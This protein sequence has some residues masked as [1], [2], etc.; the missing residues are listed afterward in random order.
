MT[1]NDGQDGRCGRLDRAIQVDDHA[2]GGGEGGCQLDTSCFAE[3]VCLGCKEKF[4]SPGAICDPLIRLAF[5]GITLGNA[6]S[7]GN[8]QVSSEFL[9]AGGTCVLRS[10]YSIR[11]ITRGSTGRTHLAIHTAYYKLSGPAG[12]GHVEWVQ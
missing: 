10:V 1:T 6:G 5:S 2:V 11:G 8:A 3:R 4:E 9:V 7:G 12:N